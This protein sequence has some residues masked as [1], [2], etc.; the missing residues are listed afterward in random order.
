MSDQ[1]ILIRALDTRWRRLRKEWDR[2]R[3]KYSKDAVHDLRVA[4]RRLI[5]VLDTLRSL[6]DDPEIEE[7]RRRVKK[8]LGALSPLRD[9][10]VQRLSVSKMARR[11][12]QLKGFQKSL[13]EKEAR[14][15]RKVKKLLR[16]G[17]KLGLVIAQAKSAAEDQVDDKAIIRVADKRYREVIRLGKMVDPSN[18]ATIHRMRLAFKKFRYTAEVVQPLIK[19]EVT[20]AR[21]RQFHA[22]Q[23]MM[24]NIQD[25]EVL[26]AKLTKWAR[27][28]EKRI[29]DLKPVLAELDRQ[30]EKAVTTFMNSAHKVHTFWKMTPPRPASVELE[31]RSEAAAFA[32]IR[33]TVPILRVA[34]PSR[35]DLSKK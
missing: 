7:C 30:K 34:S 13:T 6:V 5:A 28:E 12:P 20:S 2:T 31:T 35:R 17:T 14:A 8:S 25:I 22:F 16:K 33:E 29:E 4:A 24:G 1:N 19:K 3:S 26:S 11:F 32:E 18:T 10:Q 21:L 9:V 27:K 15:A 23:T